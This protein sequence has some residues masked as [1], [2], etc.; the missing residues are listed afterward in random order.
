MYGWSHG[1]LIV[2]LPWNPS[3]FGRTR[4]PSIAPNAA[5][6][7]EACF[8]AR[9]REERKGP[10]RRGDKTRGR[11]RG[12]RAPIYAAAGLDDT[13]SV[14]WSIVSAEL[15]ELHLKR[16]LPSATGLSMPRMSPKKKRVSAPQFGQPPTVTCG[17]GNR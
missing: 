8:G 1:C 6:A 15:H 4:R 5:H 3:Y 17:C 9:V 11:G 12:G 2:G 13:R 14:F 7:A 10:P 16:Q